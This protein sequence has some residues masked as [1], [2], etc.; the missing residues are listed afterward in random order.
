MST[1][2]SAALKVMKRNS[3]AFYVVGNN[4]TIVDDERIE[5]PTDEF[6][7]D[8]GEMAGWTKVDIM[9]MELLPSRD[10]F[11]NNRGTAETILIFRSRG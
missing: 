7:W 11:R 2:L 5:I 8:I 3:Y 6:L 10:I 9:S 1:L 4:S